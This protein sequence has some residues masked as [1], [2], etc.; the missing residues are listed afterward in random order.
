MDA[1]IAGEKFDA[2]Q[3]KNFWSEKTEAKRSEKSCL[4]K[5]SETKRKIEAKGSEK[6][7]Y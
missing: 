1:V 5:Q 4:K 6:L 7:I 2:K 3:N